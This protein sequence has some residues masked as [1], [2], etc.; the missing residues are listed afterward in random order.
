MSCQQIRRWR[1]PVGLPLGLGMAAAAALWAATALADR[2]G[3]RA[4]TARSHPAVFPRVV[5]SLT[6]CTLRL[7]TGKGQNRVFP[8]GVG[9]LTDRGQEGPLG[10][11]HT[12]PDPRDRDLYLP[13]R[14]LPAFHGGLPYL[15][16][17]RRKSSGAGKMFRPFGIHGP[18]SPTLIWGRV[19]RGC[20]RLRPADIRLLYGVAVK[21]PSM[22]VTFIRQLDRVG[23]RPVSPDPVRPPLPGCPEAAAGARKLRRLATGAQ[24]HDRV[25]GGVDHWYSIPLQGGDVTSVRLRHGGGLR[26]ELYGIRA[27]SAIASGRRGF[28]HRIPL[29]HRNRG[30]RFVRVVASSG[31]RKRRRFLPY[32]LS[33]TMSG[34][35]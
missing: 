13:R 18:V 11:L 19:S 29:A 1:A 25:C 4:K 6:G 30:D 8:V 22:P 23:G 14:R 16:L 32:T 28:V 34:S 31:A 33:V 27:I 7:E 3:P 2:P 20:I 35:R 21:H 26:V 15:R 17:D 5:V 12:G 9:R 24:I 10:T